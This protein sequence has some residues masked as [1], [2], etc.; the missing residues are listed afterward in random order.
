MKVLVVE[1]NEILSINLVKFLS[2]KDIASDVSFDGKD[3][4]TFAVESL[5]NVI[6]TLASVLEACQNQNGALIITLGAGDVKHLGK[7]IFNS[8]KNY[9]WQSI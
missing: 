4:H 9:S 6:G 3:G 5:E 1:D 7:R 8:L 2:F